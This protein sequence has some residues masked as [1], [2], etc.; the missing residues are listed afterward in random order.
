M[1]AYADNK[2]RHQGTEY[3]S[4]LPH[5][6][7]TVQNSEISWETQKGLPDIFPHTSIQMDIHIYF[8]LPS[9]QPLQDSV[10]DQP[11]AFYQL[12]IT[13]VICQIQELSL[14]KV[15]GSYSFHLEHSKQRL[16]LI[17]LLYSVNQKMEKANHYG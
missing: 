14:S 10:V 2:D 1:H 9:I 7:C 12:T 4:Q 11:Y 5:A 3:C 15:P 16:P 13:A 6:Q 8:S 17:F